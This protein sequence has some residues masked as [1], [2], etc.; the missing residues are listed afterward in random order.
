EA[1]LVLGGLVES[2]PKA[3]EKLARWYVWGTYEMGP[4]FPMALGANGFVPGP[5][6][7]KLQGW[8]GHGEPRKLSLPL[9]NGSPAERAGK[10]IAALVPMLAMPGTDAVDHGG[11]QIA[12]SLIQ[13]VISNLAP[14][15]I[16]FLATAEGRKRWLDTVQNLETACFFDPGNLS[17]RE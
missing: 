15:R 10:V 17:G 16:A 5:I 1:D 12:D 6:Q 11:K 4:G 13:G 9:A 2:D 7:V 8:D 3:W 14:I